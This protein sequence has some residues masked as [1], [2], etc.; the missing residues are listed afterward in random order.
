MKCQICHRNQSTADK[1]SLGQAR[2]NTRRF[3]KK[4]F[5]LWK[6]ANCQSLHSLSN[7]DFA[8]LY[9]DYPLNKRKLDVF[10]R[11]TLGNLIRR[12]NRE[13]INKDHSILDYGCGN[14]LLMALLQEKGHERAVGFDP[15]VHPYTKKP[16]ELF[17]C[18]VANDIIEHVADIRKTIKDA[19]AL[20]K[21]GGLLYI[22]TADSDGVE[23]DNLEPH[24]MRLHQPY[25]RT[26]L[27]EPTLH[28]LA[29][30][31]GF[32]LVRSY[33]K[34]YMDTLQPFANYRFLDEMS[35]ALDHNMDAMLNP[36]E[37]ARAVLMH[38]SL[39]LFGL[40]GYFAP[41]AYEPAVILRRRSS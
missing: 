4:A 24:I 31:T 7:V 17:D 35:K 27:N 40:V 29:L 22:G 34:S 23:M 6:C 10:A 26:I 39:I 11:G 3:M 1:Y 2:G 41:T 12:L 36:K 21:P 8:D 9:A 20:V 25:H 16:Q 28:A 37:S 5:D 33:R 13:G 15:Y 14:G 38:P 32:K 19:A 30:E 18:V